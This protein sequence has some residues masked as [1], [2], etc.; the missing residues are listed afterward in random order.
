[1]FRKE[2]IKI[3]LG[4]LILFSLAFFSLVLFKITSEKIIKDSKSIEKSYIEINKIK[5]PIEIVDNVESRRLGLSYR[6]VLDK[7]SGMLF[8][9]ENKGVVSFWMKDM[10]FP[11]DIIWIDGDKIVNISK[12]L[13]PAGSQPDLSYSSDLPIDFALEV[14]GGF[15]EENNID[16]GDE[17][18]FKL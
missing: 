16:I 1:M 17:I 8:D 7:N 15:C 10:N 12:N 18:V 5:I 13:P 6:E 2:K 3:L 4:V 14:N 11:L 9:M